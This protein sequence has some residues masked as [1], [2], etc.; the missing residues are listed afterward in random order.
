MS[1]GWTAPAVER[2]D[3]GRV[4]DE[5]T[6]LQQLLDYHRATLL[7]KCSGLTDLQLKRRAVPPS[8]LSL[9]GLIRHMTEVERWWFR[10]NA[11]GEDLAS[12]YDPDQNGADLEDTADADAVLDL[13]SYRSEIEAARNALAGKD[14]DLVV[15]SRGH[16][17]DRTMNVR[18]IYLHMIEEYAR[19]NG[20][21]D[22]LREAIDGATGV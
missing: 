13:D 17:P 1:E 21:A 19:H 22:L 5:L 9:L 8:H 6:A 20:H 14:L 10:V 2:V 3:V 16:H 12:P 15:P 7:V 4:P 18:W 11:N